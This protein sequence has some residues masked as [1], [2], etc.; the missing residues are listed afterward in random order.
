MKSCIYNGDCVDV[1]NGMMSE[2]SVDVILTS[3]PYNMTNRKD[4]NNDRYDVY[5][6]W[7]PKDKYIEWTINVFR[8]FDRVLKKNGVVLYNF[9]YSVENPDLPY[10]IV[11]AICDNTDFTI[12]DT[13]FWKK[14]TCIPVPSNSK[15]LTR[16]TEF[17][18]VFTRKNEI[19]TY[20]N[21]RQVTKISEKT[22]QKFYNI[23]YNF[24][25]AN[26]TDSKTTINKATFSVELCDKLLNIYAVPGSVVFDPFIGTGTTAVAC[27]EYGCEFIGCELSQN[28]CAYISE[29]LSPYNY[30]Y[31][32]R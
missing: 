7:L 8:G 28:Q 24:I 22:G 1:M 27:I 32:F 18:F 17:I 13:I 5:N 11:N 3:P 10:R 23:C 12:I 25:E 21:N 19:E 9:S 31:D 29:R 6:D 15:R 4:K 26:N 20:V 16:N 30:D 14:S 2:G